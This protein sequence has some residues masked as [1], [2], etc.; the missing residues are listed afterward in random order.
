[1]EKLQPESPQTQGEEGHDAPPC[2]PY[3]CCGDHLTVLNQWKMLACC[4]HVD[5]GEEPEVSQSQTQE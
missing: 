4:G 2:G 5:F 3:L 1:M